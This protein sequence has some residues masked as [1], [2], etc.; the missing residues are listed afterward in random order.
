MAA[1]PIYAKDPLRSND[2]VAFIFFSG[3]KGQMTLKLGMQ[4][5]LLQYYQVK[6]WPWVHLDLSY[7]KV[8]FCPS[9][10]C[11]GKCLNC[12][13]LRNYWSLLEVGTYCQRNEY[14]TIYDNLRS[15]S[16]IDLCPR[17]LRFNI[18]K[19]FFLKTYQAIEAQF[20]MKPPCDVG[21]KMCSNVPGHMTKISI[22]GWPWTWYTALST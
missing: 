12:I 10:F 20:H 17:P 6:W 11:M 21:N 8:K 2:F 15:R 13:F 9:C 16:F 22:F 18:F 19:L 5:S 4:H 1:M 7:S 3:T 14:T